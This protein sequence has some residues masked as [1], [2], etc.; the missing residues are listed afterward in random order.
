MNGFGGKWTE[1][2]IEVFIKYARAYL[3]VMKDRPY[4]KLLYFDGFAGSG[5]IDP[6]DDGDPYELIE[7]V[8]KRI[9]DITEPRAFDTYYFVEKNKNNADRLREL[10]KVKYP[11]KPQAG[12]VHGDCNVK[13]ID[14]AAYMRRDENK[15]VRSL[16]FLDPYGMQLSWNSLLSLRE[17]PVDT[18]ILVPT[19]IGVGRL[20]RRDGVIE[21]ALMDRLKDFLGMEEVEIMNHFYQRKTTP[22][23]F[24]PEETVNKIPDVTE[25]IAALYTDRILQ[26]GIFKYA[27]KPRIL[28]NSIGLPMYHFVLYTN[29]E[30]G[31]R[32]ADTIKT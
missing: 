32:I 18:W 3:T 28:K 17:L 12:V 30:S 5:V 6:T 8:A 24:G 16:A 7:G 14:L 2:K 1:E 10:I 13:L 9:L 23:L 31:L 11:N 19:A 26:A 29:K 25:R 22:T 21:P 27:S 15:K 4:F 20:L